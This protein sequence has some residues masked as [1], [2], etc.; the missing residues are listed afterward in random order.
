M[1]GHRSTSR[2]QYVVFFSASLRMRTSRKMVSVNR[3][4]Q[5]QRNGASFMKIGI[6][7]AVL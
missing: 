3:A 2:R 5:E 6:G 4:Q 1:R 7:T